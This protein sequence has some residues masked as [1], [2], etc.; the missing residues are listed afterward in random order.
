M[1]SLH[2]LVILVSALMVS[3]GWQVRGTLLDQSIEWTILEYE[4]STSPG[5]S[6]TLE[7]AMQKRTSDEDAEYRLT[8]SNEIQLERVQTVTESLFTGQLRMQ[9]QVEYRISAVNGGR[10]EGG[11]AVVWRDL[12][13]DETNPAA[14]EREKAFL[15]EEIDAGIV[16]QLLAHLERFAINNAGDL[17]AEK[18]EELLLEDNQD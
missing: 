4:T 2:L 18:R 11:T 12:E 3:C 5:F 14:T 6:R 17:S 8:I 7:R 13:D 1:K 16:Q 9:K 10:I 15:Q